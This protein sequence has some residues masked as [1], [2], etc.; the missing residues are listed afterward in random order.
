VKV[1]ERIGIFFI[2]GILF[3]LNINPGYGISLL[4]EN[5]RKN[6]PHNYIICWSEIP[7]LPDFTRTSK[8]QLVSIFDKTVINL[9]INIVDFGI[10]WRENE[11]NLSSF[12]KGYVSLS[13]QIVRCFDL[14]TIIFPFHFFL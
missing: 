3:Y 7:T 8:K 13:K 2:V 10:L 14:K 9:N 1:S 11:L 12:G 4:D 6:I 5:I